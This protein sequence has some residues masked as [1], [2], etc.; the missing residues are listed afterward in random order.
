MK[1]IITDKQQALAAVLRDGL[2]LEYVSEEFKNDEEVVLASVTKDWC[3]LQYASST[4]KANKDVVLD[5]VIK[6]PMALKYVSEQL[7]K[8]AEFQIQF[9]ERYKTS[10]TARILSRRSVFQDPY[11]L[12]VES[13]TSFLT[14]VLKMILLIALYLKFL[15][16]TIYSSNL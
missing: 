6:S 3:A 16:R 2:A 9:F 13:L 14:H 8:D 10:A 1:Q 7:K 11:R 5:A 12:I 4:L 15:Q